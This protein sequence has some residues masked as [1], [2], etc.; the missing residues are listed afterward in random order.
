MNST[1]AVV[2]KSFKSVLAAQAAILGLGVAACTI[3]VASHAVTATA[4][5][6]NW[7][8]VPPPP[9]TE[10]ILQVPP[11]PVMVPY[12]YAERGG[13]ALPQ[14]DTG[15]FTMPS[16]STAILRPKPPQPQPQPQPSPRPTGYRPANAPN[17]SVVYA[18]SHGFGVPRGTS[19]QGPGAAEAFPSVSAAAPV[20]TWFGESLRW[21]AQKVNSQ[22]F[23]NDMANRP[24]YG[25]PNNGYASSAGAFEN[26]PAP[27]YSSDA[28]HAVAQAPVHHHKSSHHGRHHY[29]HRVFASR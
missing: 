13:P 19:D 27:Q 17:L 12:T 20:N 9:P 1:S 2:R 29:G 25:I 23:F 24:E 8:L 6:P 26:A 15:A 16:Y 5:S 7:E 18:V 14:Q 4:K 10:P 28:P 11:P 22:Q 21:Y 3:L